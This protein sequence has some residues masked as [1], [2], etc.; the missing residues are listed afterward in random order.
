MPN[1]RKNFQFFYVTDIEN[2]EFINDLTHFKVILI[3]DSRKYI[4]EEH[5]KIICPKKL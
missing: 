1:E 2:D 3:D 5:A 4:T